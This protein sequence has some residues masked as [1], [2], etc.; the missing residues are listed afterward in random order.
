M[1]ETKK[2]KRS[3]GDWCFYENPKATG[4]SRWVARKQFGRKADGKQNIKAL[5][6]ETKAEVRKK[7]K[8][9]EEMLLQ[10]GGQV[11]L[12]KSTLYD[13]AMDW[14][15]KYKRL[16]VKAT[17]YD[18]YEDCL[19]SRL[20]PFDIARVQLCQLTADICQAYINELALV[21][22]KKGEQYT[23]PT[24][25][26]TYN[27]I[28]ACL[29]HAANEGHIIK[30][31]MKHI[32]LPS[33]DKVKHSKDSRAFNEEEVQLICQQAKKRTSNGKPIYYYGDIIVILL[34]SGMRIGECLGLRW[35]DIDFEHNIIVIDNTV[36][37]VTNR[38]GGNKKTKI[39]DTSP[40]TKKSNRTIPLSQIAKESFLS[41][42]ELSGASGNDNDYICVTKQGNL[43]DRRNIR[44]SLDSI[45]EGCGIKQAGKNNGDGLH[46]LR[47]TYTSLLFS[48]DVDIK[49]VSELL[50]HEKT[51]T[52][53]DIYCHL[54]PK[55]KSNAVAL[56]D[57][58]FSNL[59]LHGEQCEPKIN[60]TI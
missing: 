29:E 37:T 1:A 25:T 4:G 27:V 10:N 60:N 16:A 8:A 6:G 28:N 57:N 43:T 7:A 42:K 34:F 38:D 24:I 44:R 11:S 12:S 20:L 41:F 49:T 51:S 21:K 2:Q 59:V 30:N 3:N 15:E 45:L 32:S 47:H 23:L 56:L 58:N 14:L 19:T 18:A 13:Y 9:Y 22:N 55:D 54:M 50:G 31:P 5:Y 40:K 17:T 53:Y 48:S 52:T 46:V 39:V 36:T 26:K 35:K 33:A